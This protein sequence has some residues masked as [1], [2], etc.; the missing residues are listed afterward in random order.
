MPQFFA[1]SSG[2]SPALGGALLNFITFA[3]SG[4]AQ[5]AATQSGTL[6]CT[7][8]DVPSKANSIVD[9]SCNYRSVSGAEADYVGSAGTKTGGF[10]PAKFVFVWTV[11]AIDAGKAP[12][13]EGTFTTESGREGA[14]VLV[15]GKDG[16]TRLEPLTGKDQVPGPAEITNLTLELAAT[17]T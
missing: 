13:L 9:L 7:V 3:A 5:P 10:P 12:L 8:A 4:V 14:V 16:S 15:G 6:T 11:V 17:K 1:I 2:M